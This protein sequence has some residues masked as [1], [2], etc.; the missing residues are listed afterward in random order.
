MSKEMP[1]I[2]VNRVVDK[3][4]MV[5]K[6]EGQGGGEA[7]G[8]ADPKTNKNYKNYW[9]Q[10]EEA[11]PITNQKSSGRCWLFACLNVIR[12]P[13]IKEYNLDDFEFS[14]GFCFFWDK[15]TSTW[16]GTYSFLERTLSMH[17]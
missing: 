1:A 13:F 9:P 10:V 5:R 8:V 15:V 4:R 7:H 17:L 2:P 12:I 6:M 14:Q 16:K 3:K 11:K